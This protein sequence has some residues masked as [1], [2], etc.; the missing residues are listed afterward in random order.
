VAGADG[1]GQGVNAGALGE[2][3]G[4]VGVGDVFEARAAGAVAVFNAAQ[5]T[6]FALDRDAA[7]IRPL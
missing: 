2:F 6:D 3:D 7:R 4:L 5:N 1:E